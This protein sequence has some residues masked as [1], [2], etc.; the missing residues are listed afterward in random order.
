[1]SWIKDN[2]KDVVSWALLILGGTVIVGTSYYRLGVVEDAI[3]ELKG[4]V[5]A[6]TESKSTLQSHDKD[7]SRL[8]ERVGKLEDRLRPV[9]TTSTRLE[10]Q[11]TSLNEGVKDVKSQLTTIQAILLDQKGKR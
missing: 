9:E 10:T 5:K 1:M 2:I 6:N 4:A 7:I 8:S 3:V 11:L